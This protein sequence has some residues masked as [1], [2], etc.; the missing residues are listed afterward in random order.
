M[1]TSRPV[2][3]AGYG[4]YVP[5][6]RVRTAAI[7]AAWGRA[8]DG[9]LPVRE[10]SVPALDEDT[11]TMAIEAARHALARAAAPF[12]VESLRAVWVGTE[13][14]PYA[15][16]PTSTIVAEAIGAVPWVSAADFEFACK[17]GS[18]AMQAACAYVG[19]GMAEYALAVG[20]DAAQGKPGDHLEMT[21]A[22]GGA[23]F[24]FGPEETALARIEAS[25]SYV[26]D[27]ADFFRRQH[28]HY[29]EHGHRFTGEPSYFTHTRAASQALLD[30]LGRK[31]ADYRYA[32]FHQP[33]PKFMR[34]V[35]GELGFDEEQVA[36]A[37]VVDRIG[38][39]YSGASLLGLAAVLD[40]AR[41]GDRIFFCSYGSGAGSDAFSIEA[42][43]RLAAAR[44]AAP[45]VREL[46]ARRHEI[47]DYGQY[48]RLADGVRRL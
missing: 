45:S 6:P 18:E 33:N 37:A 40:V 38:N 2:G 17:A 11:A 26:T 39:T 15:V 19:S 48:L 14:K 4:A 44:D 25:F 29:P 28:M 24:L 34:R 20:M 23:A 3:I 9:R 42:T 5:R 21:A 27:T 35:A 47:T 30:S 31:A 22:A 46:V 43:P 36:A 8:A 41:A 12:A 1:K 16:K 13:S 7:A 32:V 10:K